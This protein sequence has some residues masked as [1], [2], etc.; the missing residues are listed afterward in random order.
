MFHEHNGHKLSQLDDAFQQNVELRMM[1]VEESFTQANQRYGLLTQEV[2]AAKDEMHRH[3]KLQIQSLNSQFEELARML[4]AKRQG[5]TQMFSKRFDLE[6]QALEEKVIKHLLRSEKEINLAEQHI[7]QIKMAIKAHS[8]VAILSQLF[9]N[10][11]K[12][13]HGT[14]ELINNIH[15]S[16]KEKGHLERGICAFR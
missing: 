10:F 1:Q 14:K 9:S 16:L 8:S 13:L 2:I 4:E 5:I 15:S 3:Q 12:S 6:R 7:Q 11:Q